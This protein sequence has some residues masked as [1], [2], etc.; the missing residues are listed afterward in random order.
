[1]ADFSDSRTRSVLIVAGEASGDLHGSNLVREMRRI[2]PGLEFKGIGGRRMAG[3]GVRILADASDMAVVGLTEVASR[4]KLIVENFFRLKRLLR[5]EKPGLV[6]LIDYPDFNLPLAKA[7][8]KE[9]L[10]VFYYISPQVWAWRTGRIGRLKR[11]VDRMAVIL[12]FEEPFYRRAGMQVDFVGHPLLD[13][14]KRKYSREETLDRIGL[15][16]ELPVVAILPGSREGEIR[17]IL[18]VMLSAAEILRKRIPDVQFVLTLADTLDAGLIEEYTRSSSLPV[19]IVADD[20]YDAVGSSDAAMVCSGTATVETALLETPMIVVYRVSLLTYLVGRMVV[21]VDHIGMVNIIAGKTV[22]PEFIQNG[23]HPAKMADALYDLLKD[24]PKNEA[25]R[26]ELKKI[27][28]K[29][30]EP[31]AAER[32]ARLAC[33]LLQS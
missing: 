13:A 16:A 3:A 32:A 15:D 17:R 4:L 22:A 20:A 24:R 8:R 2:D 19:R 21:S 12:P 23:A 31:G 29:L 30:G 11:D 9:G 28:K 1:M 6:I 26:E 7:A 5:E 27:A 33:N 18:P 10:R 14:V 25:V